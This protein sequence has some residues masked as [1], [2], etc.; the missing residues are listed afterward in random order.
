M[1]AKPRDKRWALA[2]L[3]P[4]AA[5]VVFFAGCTGTGTQQ[6]QA[7]VYLTEDYP[8]FNYDENGTAHG[9][10]VDL[11]LAATE[12]AGEPIDADAIRFVPWSEG[13]RQ[14]QSGPNTVLFSTVRLAERESE[15]L[16]A[17]PIASEA[18]VLF[19]SNTSG[20]TVE[21]PADLARYR[22]GVVT[23]DAAIGELADLGIEPGTLVSSADPATLAAML[24]DSEI[25]LWCHGRGQGSTTPG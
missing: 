6:Q 15:F 2:L 12:I 13:Y 4:L 3:I 24:R 14:A 20:V 23:D 9:I 18:K 10:A 1:N 5:V 19:A 7:T 17:G 11:L 8:P 22:I 16:W 21:S 25:D